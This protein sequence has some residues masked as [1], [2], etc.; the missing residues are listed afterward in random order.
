MEAITDECDS[1]RRMFPLVASHERIEID[2]QVA[3]DGSA[4][5]AGRDL[6]RPGP[7]T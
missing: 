4:T 6:D 1:I 5:L 7:S 3:E 2:E